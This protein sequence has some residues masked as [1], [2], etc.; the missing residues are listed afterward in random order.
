MLREFLDPDV[1]W[2]GGNASAPDACHNRE[3]ALEFMRQARSRQGVGELVDVV[4][5]GDKVV[6]I[7]RPPSED[8]EPAA[9]SANLTTFRGGKAIEMVHYPNPQRRPCRRRRQSAVS[10]AL[11]AAKVKSLRGALSAATI[12]L[13][14]LPPRNGR[15]RI[16]LTASARIARTYRLIETRRHDDSVESRRRPSVEDC[17]GFRGGSALIR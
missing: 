15:L 16:S 10:A 13:C 8:G 5:A 4:D 9:L 11:S 17:W 2:H 6:V 3:Q 1:K 7:M 12:G 14:P